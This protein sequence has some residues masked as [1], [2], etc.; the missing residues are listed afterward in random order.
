MGPIAFDVGKMVGNLLLAFFA[1]D[2]LACAAEPRHAQRRWLLEA[3]RPPASLRRAATTACMSRKP[4]VRGGGVRQGEPGWHPAA[5]L[6][7]AVDARL[8]PA[9]APGQRR[10]RWLQGA[11]SAF[12]AQLRRIPPA[13]A[14][15]HGAQRKP[16]ACGQC[17]G[18]GSSAEARRAAGPCGAVPRSGRALTAAAAHAAGSAGDVPRV[19]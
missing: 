8:A 2:G 11:R 15:P 13:E 7:L 19:Y 9:V 12:W 1:A 3:R 16:T 5:R 10:R 14:L 6:F 17:S 4:I 18:P